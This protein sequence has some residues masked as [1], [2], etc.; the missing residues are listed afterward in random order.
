M[1]INEGVILFNPCFGVDDLG[2]CS[3]LGTTHFA[4]SKVA[5]LAVHSGFFLTLRHS[6][7][8]HAKAS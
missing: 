4:L 8:E 5:S 1:A 6:R 3:Q 2:S 7:L